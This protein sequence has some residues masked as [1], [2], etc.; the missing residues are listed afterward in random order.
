MVSPKGNLSRSKEYFN[1]FEDFFLKCSK[2]SYPIATTSAEV[3]SIFCSIFLFIKLLCK[4]YV[5]YFIVHACCPRFVVA[6]CNICLWKFVLIAHNALPTVKRSIV[7]RYQDSKFLIATFLKWKSETA[8]MRLEEFWGFLKKYFLV[9][10][11]L[12]I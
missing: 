3:P 1:S 2:F 9:C 12:S 7:S 10:Y 4:N 11:L 8:T 6:C 5:I